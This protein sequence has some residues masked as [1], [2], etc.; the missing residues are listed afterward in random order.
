MASTGTKPVGSGTDVLFAGMFA[1][2][3]LFGL[4]W[5]A[6]VASAVLCGHPVPHGHPAG[7]FQ[8]FAHASDP[9]AAWHAPVGPAFVYWMVTA[10]I[11]GSLCMSGFFG[12]RLWRHDSTKS[13]NDPTCDTRSHVASGLADW[14]A[15]R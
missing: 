10:V 14:R 2:I 9:S 12:W 7:A 11:T 8:A 6:G 15:D 3:G 1:L 4:L 5:C 13:K